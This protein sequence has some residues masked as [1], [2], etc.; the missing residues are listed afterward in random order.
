MTRSTKNAN[1]PERYNLQQAIVCP[2]TIGSGVRTTQVRTT[3]DSFGEKRVKTAL[4]SWFINVVWQLEYNANL[5][6]HVVTL[7]AKFADWLN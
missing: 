6:V 5:A 2:A 4:E 3:E 1:F 7:P